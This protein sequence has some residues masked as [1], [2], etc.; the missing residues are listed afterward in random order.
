[1]KDFKQSLLSVASLVIV[2]GTSAASH[3]QDDDFSHVEIETIPVAED[4]YMLVGEG[5]NIGILAGEEGVFM[6]DNQFAPLTEKIT[7]VIAAIT[8]EP[9]RFFSQYPL[10]F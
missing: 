7:D 4:I 8:P 3:A 6:V 10:A 2:L 9:I 1:M 5:G